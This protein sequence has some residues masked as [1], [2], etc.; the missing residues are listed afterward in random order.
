MQG[1]SAQE[2]AQA[3]PVASHCAELTWR[4]PRPEERTQ[5][6][7]T[8]CRDLA[9]ELA[10]ELAPLLSGGKL[11][12]SIAEPEQVSAQA[13]FDQIG[14]IAANCLLRC[15]EGDQ[16]VLFSL[17]YATAIGLTDF[18]FGGEGSLP[19]EMPT[20]LPRSAAML[21]EQ[22]ASTVAQTIVMTNGS[23]ERAR[24]DVLVRSE[25]VT[26]L[27]PFGAD[28]EVALFKLSISRGDASDW[29]A[30]FAVASDR[31]DGLLPGL[32]A[33]RIRSRKGREPR[34]FSRSGF[35]A[36]PLTLEAVVGEI[37]LSL[38]RLDQLKPGDEIPLTVCRDLPLRIGETVFARGKVGRIDS[39]LALRVTS[40]GEASA[41]RDRWA[42]RGSVESSPPV[43]AQAQEAQS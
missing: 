10:Q 6:I 30:L 22:F 21:V 24:G 39:N 15:G 27:K 35:A 16:T 5:A 23:A 4:G 34:D 17:D 29:T 7:S 25:S 3:R 8:W 11:R 42:S 2:L 32:E 12:V 9:Q 13:V 31:V 38:G 26:R 28:A 43:Q 20:Q 14:P 36:M 33:V 40:L 1:I 19:D 18:S 37:D 41:P